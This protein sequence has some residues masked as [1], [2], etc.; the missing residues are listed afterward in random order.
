MSD[1]FAL[2]LGMIFLLVLSLVN[3]IVVLGHVAYINRVSHRIT[4]QDGQMDLML[5]M[6]SRQNNMLVAIL[7]N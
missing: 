2:S 3:I 7:E 6:L 5:D 4:Y 1:N